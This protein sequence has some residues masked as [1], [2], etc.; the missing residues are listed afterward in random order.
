[1]SMHPLQLRLLKKFESC[2]KNGRSSANERWNSI[3]EIVCWSA[4]TFEKSGWIVATSDAVRVIGTAMSAPVWTPFPPPK[5]DAADPSEY[6]A[7]RDFG[8]GA[9]T[10]AARMPLR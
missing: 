7:T 5:A 2:V 3:G 1:M 9:C 6:S 10:C 4:S 8:H